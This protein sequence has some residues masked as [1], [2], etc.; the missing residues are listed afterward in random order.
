[1]ILTHSSVLVGYIVWLI[2]GLPLNSSE[3]TT[4]EKR[5]LRGRGRKLKEVSALCGRCLG[6]V[7]NTKFKWP[8]PAAV[9]GGCFPRSY[10]KHASLSVL[11]KVLPPPPPLRVGTDSLLVNFLPQPP[12]QGLKHRSFFTIMC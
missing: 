9:S 7:R 6:G 10:T 11:V 5:S 4:Y 2:I 1:M 8:Q 12:G 3:A